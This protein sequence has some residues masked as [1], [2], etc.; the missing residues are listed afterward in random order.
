MIESVGRANFILSMSTIPDSPPDTSI[1]TPT[2]TSRISTPE[3]GNRTELTTSDKDINESN[4]RQESLAIREASPNVKP[5]SSNVPDQTPDAQNSTPKQHENNEK[6]NNDS[7][8]PHTFEPFDWEGFESRYAT[9][10]ASANET[11]AAIRQ[12]FHAMA[13]VSYTHTY[14]SSYPSP[15]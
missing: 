3:P 7:S 14:L 8:N 2:I 11:E 4:F 13:D 1:R 12:Q 10:M 9:A 6:N 15:S 5:S